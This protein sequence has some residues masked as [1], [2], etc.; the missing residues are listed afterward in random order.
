MD[1]A[2]QVG[3][4]ESGEAGGDIV[5]QTGYAYANVK[6][7]VAE[8]NATMDNIVDET[9]FVTDMAEVMETDHFSP[10][11]HAEHGGEELLLSARVAIPATFLG[12]P[13]GM[14]GWL[15]S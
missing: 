4:R 5:Q 2:G 12:Q 7:V 9:L 13:A 15:R 14:A 11:F 10:H 6:S 3:V 1:L 8:F